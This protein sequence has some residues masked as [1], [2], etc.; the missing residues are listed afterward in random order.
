MFQTFDKQQLLEPGWNPLFKAANLQLR[1]LGRGEELQILCNDDRALSI[2][3]N[4][5]PFFHKLPISQD[6]EVA[7]GFGKVAK[8]ESSLRVSLGGKFDDL[9]ADETVNHLRLL[10][11]EIPTMLVFVQ[12]PFTSEKAVFGF[13]FMGQ[14]PA[15]EIQVDVDDPSRLDTHSF[16]TICENSLGV[17]KEF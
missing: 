1:F 4:S 6:F 15:R 10:G 7:V 3:L 11:V 5:N 2:T 12:K 16:R 17:P 14:I 8:A 9:S 13:Q